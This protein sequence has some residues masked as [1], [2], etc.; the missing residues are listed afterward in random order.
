M[1]LDLGRLT[2]KLTDLDKKARKIRNPLLIKNI[3]KL[4]A[5]YIN[6]LGLDFVNLTK[7]YDILP[8]L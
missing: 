2:E 5:L 8:T 1:Q 4:F 7:F 3:L 6:I